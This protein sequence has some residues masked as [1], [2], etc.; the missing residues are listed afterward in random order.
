MRNHIVFWACFVA[1]GSTF[2]MAC[3]SADEGWT[4]HGDADSD[5]DTDTD[6][7]SDSDSDS[8]SD[9][10]GDTETEY[11]GPAIPETCE[12]AAQATTTVGCLFYAIDLDS[13]DSVETQQYAVVVSNVN[14]T[15]DANVTVYKGNPSTSGWDVHS[16]AVVPPMSLYTFNLE[17]YHMNHSGTMPKG[18]YKVES[19]VPIVA[20]QFNPVDGASSYLSD[21]TLLIPVPS[22]S[23]TYDVIG[24]K[25]SCSAMCDG[26]M[27]AYFTVV[28]TVDGTELVVTPSTA[29]LA[30][31]VV[32]GTG[33]VF[34]VGLDEGD[35]LEV[36]TNAPYATMTGSRI[37]SNPDH[38]IA[39]FSG[40]ECAFIPFEVFACDHPEEQLP[41]LRFWGKEF[42]GARMPIRSLVDE[43]DAVLWQ[44]YASEDTQVTV[45]ADPGVVG[46]PIGTFSM[47]AGELQE[48][49][50]SGIQAAPGDLYISSEKPIGVMQYMIG[51]E[52][53]N[54]NSIG[55]P[56]MVY[57]SPTEQFLQRYVVLVP[58]TWIND[59][60]VI[61]RTEGIGVFLD[62]VEIPDSSFFSVAGSGYEVARVMA[63]D[64]VHSLRSEDETIGLGV[65]VVGWDSYDSYAYIGGM[66]MGAINPII[67]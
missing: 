25:Q 43:T 40:Q 45:A 21:A 64:G 32:P 22:L 38:P 10:D 2:P 7:D 56:A 9:T 13:H 58:G 50:A 66:G 5:T 17:D 14:Q 39:V 37:E 18:T 6:T 52:N 65:M 62:D 4:A 34:T 24:W 54:C 55:D 26:D 33:E 67:E 19:D 61:T 3:E 36:A 42:I 8:D 46:A 30:G 31:G 49:Y 20:Y 51:S 12:Q 41:G 35:V 53:P 23:L 44:I 15:N 29:P 57:V 59:M 63:A 16:T 60:L 28:A 27:L 11:T 47:A 48:F 1:L